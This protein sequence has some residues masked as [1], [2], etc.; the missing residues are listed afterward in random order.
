MLHWDEWGEM[1]V[2][3]VFVIQQSVPSF[4]S[5]SV[6][7]AAADHFYS[8]TEKGT[9]DNIML[10]RL[11]TSAALNSTVGFTFTFYVYTF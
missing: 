1:D 5:F 9:L 3:S 2:C 10:D 4:L 11:R 8:A 6:R 7:I